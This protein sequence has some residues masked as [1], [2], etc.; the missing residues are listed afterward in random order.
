MVDQG[1]KIVE[2]EMIFYGM[3]IFLIVA[4]KAN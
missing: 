1:F 3:S 4:E 2:T